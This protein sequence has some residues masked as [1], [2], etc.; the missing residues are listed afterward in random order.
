MGLARVA[1][2]AVVL[3][4]V[5]MALATLVAEPAYAAKGGFRACPVPACLAPCVLG[6][7]PEVLCKFDGGGTAKTTFACC[8]CGG[9]G[10]FWRP[11]K[12]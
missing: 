7:E 4:V 3:G 12:K 11:L 6:A 1:V 8:C 5:A 10:N 2:F 9:G